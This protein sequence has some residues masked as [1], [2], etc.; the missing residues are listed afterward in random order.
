MKMTEKN[1]QRSEAAAKFGGGI[2]FTPDVAAIVTGRSRT[3]IFLA[4]K[5]GELIAKKDGGATIIESDQLRS[6]ISAMPDASPASRRSK[7]QVSA[8]VDSSIQSMKT[9]LQ[10]IANLIQGIQASINQLG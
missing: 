8:P 9:R 1:I 3:R 2:A 6:W 4:I 7:V 5:N 10:Q